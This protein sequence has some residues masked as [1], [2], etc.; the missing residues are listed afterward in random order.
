MAVTASAVIRLSYDKTPPSEFRIFKAG[1]NKSRKGTF[2]FTER[3][4]R[5][6]MT[7]SADFAADYP[8]DFNH[9]M[10]SFSLGDP[11]E[12]GKAAGWFQLE[13]RNGDLWATNVTWTELAAQKLQAREYRYISPTFRASKDGE[14]E[15]LLNVALTNIP[16]LKGL[17]PLMASQAQLFAPHE[18][19][20][21]PPMLEKLISMLSLASDSAESAAL[22]AI[23][24]LVEDRKRLLSATGKSSV[25]EVLG[26]WEALSLA[27]KQYEAAAKELET[28]KVAQRE[29]EVIALL[30]AG[31]KEKKIT[32]AQAESLKTKGLEDPAFLRSFL[33]VAPVLVGGPGPTQPAAAPV[34]I[35]LSA[36][37]EKIA[38]TM[39]LTPERSAELR[40]S[41]TKRS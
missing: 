4:A 29:A 16:A 27:A 23:G 3:S 36:E 26:G 24:A 19:N 5:D 14:V 37:A 28:L 11:A 25:G 2:N 39:G 10:F 8:I 21:R 34:E 20:E 12:A 38:K 13:T 9:S 35:H 22:S 40:A 33:S 41:V 1:T 7:L 32:P 6:V 15:E 17:S 18:T 31:V 30:D